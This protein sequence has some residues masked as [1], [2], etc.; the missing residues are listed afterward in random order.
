MAYCLQVT[1]K[2]QLKRS[3]SGQTPRSVLEKF[4]AVQMLD[5]HLPTTDGREVGPVLR[6]LIPQSS[7]SAKSS[8]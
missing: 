1:L 5:V 6:N 8:C 2:V 3:A 4:A 7:C